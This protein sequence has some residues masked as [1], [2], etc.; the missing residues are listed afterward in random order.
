MSNKVKM[1][2]GLGNPGSEYEQTRHNAGFWFIDELAWQYKATLKEEKKFFGSV[3]RISISGS[4]LWLLK[5]S[6]FMNRSG[7]AVAALAQFYKI[8]PEEILVVHDEL[9]IPCGRIKFKL[10][11]GNG[12]HNG[13]KDIQARLGTPDFYRLRLGIDHP[14][15]RNLVVGYV[16]NKPSPEHR[17]QIDEA[18]NKSLKA[19]PILLAGEWEEAVRFLHSK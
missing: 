8:K 10:G 6:T 14:G 5:P 4:D 2:V 18:I 9:D 13:L 3:A 12:G 19:V 15:D 16:L 1:M 7:Q 17:Q 11:G